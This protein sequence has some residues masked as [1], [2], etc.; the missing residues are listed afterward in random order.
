MLM[1]VLSAPHSSSSAVV[2]VEVFS[3]A[4][5]INADRFLYIHVSLQSD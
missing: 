4:A 2:F 3:S 1:S 5:Y